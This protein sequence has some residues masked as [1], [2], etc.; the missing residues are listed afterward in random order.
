MNMLPVSLSLLWVPD[1]V[2]R[3][4]CVALIVSKNTKLFCFREKKNLFIACTR[5]TEV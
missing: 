2:I 5:G 1:V 3:E 4:E